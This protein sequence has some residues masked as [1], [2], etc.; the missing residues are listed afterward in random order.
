MQQSRQSEA[1][2][3]SSRRRATKVDIS[4]VAALVLGAVLIGTI[5]TGL[6]EG[7]SAAVHPLQTGSQLSG[8][9]GVA[10]S[11]GSFGAWRGTPITIGGTWDDTP[12][13]NQTIDTISPGSEWG[14]WNGALD[15][16]IGSIYESRG[17]TW[18]QAAAGRYDR[19]WRLSLTKIRSY[20]AGRSGQLYIR[21]AHEFNT[22]TAPWTVHSNEAKNFRL[23]W[24]R[25][26]ALQLRVIPTAKLVFCP[27]DGSTP[28]LKLDWRTAFPGR[29]YV[30]LMSVD[31]YNQYPWVNTSAR[32]ASKTM[33]FDT[34][35]APAGIER[36]RQYAQQVGLPMAVSEWANNAVIGD[37]PVYMSAMKAWFVAHA[38]TG[39]GQV[40]YEVYFNVNNYGDRRFEIYPR[41]RMPLAS[42]SYAA[43]F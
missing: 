38:G 22:T 21:F 9:S 2:S 35:G 18:A 40:P 4:A 30:D 6:T 16:A 13:A 23:A 11:T 39:A 29:A 3:T 7:A 36:H 19:R 25:F 32:F 5:Q 33:A 15:L 24:R 41:T 31:T 20:W 12:L 8:A 43:A 42:K 34:L 37:A 1:P 26:R 28:R 27:N 14:R 10:A 17:E